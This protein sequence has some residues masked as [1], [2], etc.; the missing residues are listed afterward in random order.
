[1]LISRIRKSFPLAADEQRVAARMSLGVIAAVT[2]LMLVLAG[3]SMGFT[4]SIAFSMQPSPSG[5]PSGSPS[6]TGP[7]GP[8]IFLLNPSLSYDPHFRFTEPPRDPSDPANPTADPDPPKISDEYDGTDERYHVVAVVKNPPPNVL[9]EAYYAAEGQNEVTV[10]QLT[11]V[12]GS[13]DTYELVWNVPENTIS[14]GFGTFAVRMFSQTASGFEEV[15]AHEVPVRMQ[16]DTSLNLGEPLIEEA[17]TVELLWP[18][19]AGPL[20]F[21]KPSGPGGLWRTIVNGT[22]SQ[23]VV[24]TSS[25]ETGQQG[26]RNVYQVRLFYSVSPIGVEPVYKACGTITPSAP[27]ADFSRT[28]AGPCTLVGE[29]VPSQ[30]TA[31]AALAVQDQETDDPGSGAAGANVREPSQEGAD[32]H[33]VQPYVPDPSELKIDLDS[34]PVPDQP[35]RRHEQAGLRCL[36]Y[37]VTVTD[38]LDRP[39]QGANVDIHVTGPDDQIRF[40]EDTSAASANGADLPPDKGHTSIE[41]L[42]S[43]DPTI[44]AAEAAQQGDHNVPGDDDLKHLESQFGTG[45]TGGGGTSFGQWRFHVYSA[46]LGDSAITAWV[47]DESLTSESERRPADDDL[48]SATAPQDTNFA[49]WLPSAP[50]VTI[51]PTGATAPAGSCQRFVVRV[52]GGARAVRGANVDVHATGPNND[53]DF[54]DP[55]DASQRQAPDRGTGHNAEDQGE[56]AHAGQPPVAQHTEGETNDQGNFVVGIM[57]PVAGDT[58]LTA[59]YDGGEAPFDNDDQA[60]GEATS[61]ATTNWIQSTGDAAISFLN[62]SPYG[63]VTNVGRKE[64]VDTA[65]HIVTRVS[66][67]LPVPGVEVFYRS[68]TA[69]LVKIADATRVGES[70]T[71]EA[72]WPVDVADG[73]YTLVARIKDTNITVEQSVTVNNSPTQTNPQ[74]VPFE[75]LEITAPLDGQRAS[76]VRGK[77]T[78]RGVASAGAEGFH[79]YYT[80]ASSLATPGSGA[81]TQCGTSTLPSGSAPKEWTLDCTLQ[82]SDQPAMVTGVAAFAYDCPQGNCMVQRT[83]HSGDAH[84]VFG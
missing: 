51:D 45:L 11:P 83:S 19:Q 30:V 23:G 14:P 60:T 37:T 77:L 73:S 2:C 48:V 17:E 21:Y 44:G 38:Q 31:V 70:D 24:G 84:R 35:S 76:F 79:L 5:S 32:A 50:A 27:R 52:R 1:M 57:S 25:P 7:A 3:A 49:Q 61:T 41:R 59:W 58:T 63:N 43:C 39:V 80:R 82:G 26:N 65:Y 10:G 6:P 66:S 42:A 53:L 72:Y 13:D 22:T 29:D 40:G 71:F 12:P 36:T 33:R 54:C 8:Q 4:G 62:P 67:L 68:G 69:P 75:T 34:S 15:A 64:D 78:M 74:D 56:M 46:S 81:W 18:S 28:F 9:I 55:S 16:H 47:D 20:G